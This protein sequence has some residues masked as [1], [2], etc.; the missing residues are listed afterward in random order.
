MYMCVLY[1]C[2]NVDVLVIIMLL[3]HCPQIDLSDLHA[4]SHTSGYKMY[5]YLEML[6]RCLC[7]CA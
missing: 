6:S 7:N 4:S 3:C 2:I 1:T 5:A